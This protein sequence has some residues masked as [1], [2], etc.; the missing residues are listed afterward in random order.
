VV[1]VDEHAASAHHDES[2]SADEA[3]AGFEALQ[4]H[5]GSLAL[6]ASM[7]SRSVSNSG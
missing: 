4:I 6:A 7:A 3:G 1:I 2:G 5:F